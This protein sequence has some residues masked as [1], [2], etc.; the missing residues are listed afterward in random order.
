V[1]ASAPSAPIEATAGGA[2]L[3]QRLARA[4][5]TE[6]AKL[7]AQPVLRLIVVLAVLGPFAFG[8]LLKIQSG[9]PS[10]A[11]FGVYVH[12]SGFAVSL[13]VLSFAGN[14]GVP[15]IAGLVAGDMFSGEDRH[16]T[17][18]TILTRSCSLGDLFGAKLLA[19]ASVVCGLVL[20][21]GLASIVAGIVF[22][23][24]HPLVNLGGQQI[25][26]GRALGL[27]ALAWLL[28]LVPALSYTG[29]AILFSV[30]SR[31]GIVGVVG[32]LVAAMATL[33]LNL[34]GQGVWVHLLLVGATFTNEFGLFAAHAFLGPLAVTL[35][36]GLVWGV[37]SLVAAWLILRRRD[38]LAGASGV[39]RAGWQ[40]PAR[41]AVAVAA[42]VGLLALA[43]NLGP[44]GVTKVRVQNAV[45]ATFSNASLLQ[46]ALIGRHPPAGARLDVQPYCGRG[47]GVRSRGPGD[48]LCNVFVYLPQPK[49]V[50]FQRTNVEYDVS[51]SSN[52]CFK[53]ESPPTF[54][55]NPTMTTPS[56]ARTTNPLYV[57]YG[58]FNPL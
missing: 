20:L 12:D 39:H 14:W 7:A 5:R 34:I 51:V 44:V 1:S 55:G 33:L 46:Q 27:T 3:D 30:A 38:F 47:A 6:I 16:N 57:V 43:C 52:G 25:S 42:T 21:A 10:D 31:N 36:A 45:A 53:A 58:C 11:L 17:W 4:W 18:K 56:G 9:T 50:P 8:L 2:A 13:V 23:G 37:G 22:V 26:G 49:S 15:I 19:A 41:L 48:W 40:V 29:L 54:I 35:I 24:A 32:P 28:C